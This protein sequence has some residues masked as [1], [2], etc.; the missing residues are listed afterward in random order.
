MRLP[1]SL[2]LVALFLVA[3]DEKPPQS[4][5]SAQVGDEVVFSLNHYPNATVRLKVTGRVGASLNVQA[6]VSSRGKEWQRDY[7]I[8]GGS[9]APL[10]SGTSK[11]SGT[12]LETVR[13]LGRD[14]K[15]IASRDPTGRLLQAQCPERPLGLVGGLLFGERQWT[16][17][18]YVV[19]WDAPPEG[20]VTVAGP[21]LLGEIRST[22]SN[23]APTPRNFGS[24]E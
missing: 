23:R 4:V 7:T 19:G 9:V 22:V 16:L 1:R 2:S 18:S 5:P 24:R 3:C 6:T 17:E 10:P 11:L 15:C 13:H 14:W 12:T 20:E 21:D 8:P